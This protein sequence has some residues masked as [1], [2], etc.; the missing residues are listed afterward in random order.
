MIEWFKSIK[1]K[2][3]CTFLVFSI[4]SFYPSIAS[5]LLNGALKF[6]KE[7]IPIANSD[8]KIMMH[9]EKPFFSMKRNH[10]VN[11][12]GDENFVVPMGCDDWPLYIK[13]NKIS[14]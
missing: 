3:Q 8:F 2:Q 14:I 12:K 13:Q 1:N 11:E 10:G 5:D 6:A 4:E 7:I 9:S